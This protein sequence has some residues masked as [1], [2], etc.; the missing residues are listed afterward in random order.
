MAVVGRANVFLGADTAS[1]TSKMD[2][3]RRDMAS[4]SVKMNRSLAKLDRGFVRVG[5]SAASFAKRAI[6]IRGAIGLLAGTG[7][8]ALLVKRSLDAADSISKLSDATGI[9]TT[10]IQQLRF[11]LDRSGVS[12]DTTDKA[13]R[14]FVRN[15]GKLG[16]SS[17]ETQ[18]ALRDLDPVL[19]ANFKS[20]ESGLR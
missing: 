4:S 20:L 10:K 5:K 2:K 6:S 16:R 9:G 12:V 17:S 13:L 18:T 15:M 11:A 7:G 8:L 1:F 19:L 3:A 14:K